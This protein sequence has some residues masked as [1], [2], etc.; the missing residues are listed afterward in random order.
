MAAE[1]KSNGEVLTGDNVTP[2]HRKQFSDATE[3]TTTNTSFEDSGTGF[4][5]TV[6]VDSLILG[7]YISINLS[8]SGGTKTVSTS[9]ELEG[10]N[11]GT[12]FLGL[13]KAQANAELTLFITSTETTLLS[14]LNTAYVL[15]HVSGFT[16]LKILDASTTL[17]VR[18]KS[19]DGTSLSI[20]DVAIDVIYIG[21]FIED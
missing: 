21:R 9:L 6:D 17:K 11:L 20:K 14:H 2:I 18:M 19:S 1:E 13:H 16:P 15:Q 3:R 7:F 4:T 10:T 8:G 5:L 12:V